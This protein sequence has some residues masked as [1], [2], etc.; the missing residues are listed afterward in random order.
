MHA[1]TRGGGQRG[2]AAGKKS[3]KQNADQHY[4]ERKPVAC[5]HCSE[6]FSSRNA[7]TS[8]ASISGATKQSPMPRAKMKVSLPRRTFLSWAMSSISRSAWG[9]HLLPSRLEPGKK[10]GIRD[11]PVFGDFSVARA[12]FTRGQRVEQGAV[13]DDE[14]RLVKGADQILALGR[15]DCRLAADRRIDLGQQ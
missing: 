1:G 5:G 9:K 4:N 7:R 2:F 3:R 12:K 6:S 8:S 14:N 11:Q 10:V 15:V 13:G